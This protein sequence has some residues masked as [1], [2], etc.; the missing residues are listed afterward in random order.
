MKYHSIDH[1]NLSSEDL[2]LLNSFLLL[3]SKLFFTAFGDNNTWKQEFML[4]VVFFAG[5]RGGGGGGW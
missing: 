4:F 5:V 1:I 3:D 2:T